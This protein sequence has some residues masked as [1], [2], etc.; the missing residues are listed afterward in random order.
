MKHSNLFLS[1]SGKRAWSRRK[2]WGAEKSEERQY[3]FT[4]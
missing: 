3:G 4:C 1:P 2:T